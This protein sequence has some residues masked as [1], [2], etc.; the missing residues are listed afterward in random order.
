MSIVYGPVPSWR[1]GRSLGVDPVSTP[2]KTCSF[3]CIYCQLGRTRHPLT[4]RAA[5]R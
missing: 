1:L 3:D 5:S 2:S 4:E